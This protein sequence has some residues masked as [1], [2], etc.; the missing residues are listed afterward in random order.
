MPVNDHRATGC[1]E[2][3]IGSLKSFVLY[4]ATGKDHGKLETMVERELSALTIAPKTTPKK[5]ANRGPSW[6]R[7]QCGPEEPYKKTITTKPKFKEVLRKKPSCSDNEDSRANRMLYPTQ[8]N[9][10][11]ISDDEY[12][13]ELINHTRK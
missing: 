8:I 6:S 11:A 10:N 2:R 3:T 1:I 5:L 7:D 9:C 4:Y 12:D 13:V